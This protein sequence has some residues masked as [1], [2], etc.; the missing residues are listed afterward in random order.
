MSR[1]SFLMRPKNAD[2]LL[3]S[4]EVTMS[5]ADWKKLLP[6]LETGMWPALDFRAKISDMVSAANEHW[7]AQ[8]E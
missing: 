7:S 8:S 4:M 3:Y 1:A 5:L 2:G 6:Q